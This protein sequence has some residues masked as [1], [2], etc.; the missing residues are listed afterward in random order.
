MRVPANTAGAME[1]P[2]KALLVCVQSGNCFEGKGTNMVTQYFFG[3]F[4][5]SRRTSF[6][7]SSTAIGGTL[8]FQ[9]SASGKRTVLSC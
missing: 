6:N 2:A 4:R 3:S 9:V 1:Q 8:C 5:D 7:V